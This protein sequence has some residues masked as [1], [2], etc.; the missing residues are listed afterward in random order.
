MC[1]WVPEG[2]ERE[3][4]A[5]KNIQ[6]NMLEICQLQWKT[7]LDSGSSVNSKQNGK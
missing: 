1:S 2:E 5:E 3:N 6:R 4:E 7:L